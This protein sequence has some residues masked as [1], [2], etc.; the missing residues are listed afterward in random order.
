MSRYR[1]RDAMM[2]VTD[3]MIVHRPPTDER[4][5]F[6]DTVSKLQYLMGSFVYK[7]SLDTGVSSLVYVSN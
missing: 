7:P 6:S 3:E 5:A 4:I 2:N 1:N